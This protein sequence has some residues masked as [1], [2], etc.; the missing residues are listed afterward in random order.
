MNLKL[1]IP[2][3]KLKK[4]FKKGSS[5]I[6]PN[7]YW[8]IALVCVF[9]MVVFAFLYGFLL[10]QRVNK[11]LILSIEDA[12]RSYGTSQAEKINQTLLY[13][14]ARALKSSEIKTSPAPIVDPS[15]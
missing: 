12:D 3:F 14:A 9:L 7:S 13:F 2:K 10:F 11:E 5:T 8:E 4:N 15:L 1:K 6:D